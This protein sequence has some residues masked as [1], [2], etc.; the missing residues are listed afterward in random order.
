MRIPA[1]VLLVASVYP[2]VQSPP[3]STDVRALRVVYAD[4]RKTTTPISDRGRVSWTP[5]FPRISGATAATEDGLPLK[6]LQFEEAR[7]GEALRVTLALL[8]GT[9]HERRVQVTTVRVTGEEPVRV[10]ALE[11]FGVKPVTLSIVT[12]PPAQLRIPSVISPSSELG[13]DVELMEGAVPAY[14]VNIS[15]YSNRPVMMMQFKAYRGKTISGQGRA[16]GT[17]KVPLIDPGTRY[18]LKLN[19]TP[20]QGRS[21]DPGAWLPLDRIEITSVL[22][23]DGFVEGDATV[24]DDERALDAGT[25]QQLDRLL[26]LLR[27]VARDPSAR[28]AA[29][30]RELVAAVPIVVT[31][32]EA[33]AVRQTLTAQTPLTLGQ[34]QMTMQAGMRNARSGV[35]NDIDQ[36]IRDLPGADAAAYTRWLDAVIKK[37]D[38]WRSRIR[39][40][41]LQIADCRLPSHGL[42]IG[43][44]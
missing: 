43:D 2:Q 9:P 24:A 36:F 7:D 42:S 10:D 12:L 39:Q 6:A 29:A 15:N 28:P 30:V 8:Y 1:L 21:S 31:P 5:A 22:W 13:F 32:D 27:E 3:A 44:C 41:A 14:H 38:D 33:A 35:L 18:I 34:V 23:G 20:N 11:A 19:A 37:F 4:G 16:R 40:S 25:A 26:A 17:G